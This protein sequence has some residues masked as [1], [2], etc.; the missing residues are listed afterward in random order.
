MESTFISKPLLQE[1]TDPYLFIVNSFKEIHELNLR[2]QDLEQENK[3]YLEMII[4]YS[5]G[6]RNAF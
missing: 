3:K 5:K 2:I 4:K 1:S 6:D